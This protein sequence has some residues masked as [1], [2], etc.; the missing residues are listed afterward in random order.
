MNGHLHL[1]P[2]ILSNLSNL[3]TQKVFM[4]LILNLWHQIPTILI[5]SLD[6]LD[7]KVDNQEVTQNMTTIR[8]SHPQKLS[9]LKVFSR[10]NFG[11]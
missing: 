4:N 9:F 6:F 7:K 2:Q 8:K 1:D 10:F 5:H 11:Q 3:C